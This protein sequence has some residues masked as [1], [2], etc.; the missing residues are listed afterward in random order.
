M[1]N[2]LSFL[3]KFSPGIY[4]IAL[5]FAL[6]GDNLDPEYQTGIENKLS[7]LEKFPHETYFK[8]PQDFFSSWIERRFLDDQ[9]SRFCYG[10]E[11]Q[12]LTIDTTS[13]S[14]GLFSQINGLVLASDLAYTSDFGHDFIFVLNDVTNKRVLTYH[15]EEGK[16]FAEDP[17]SEKLLI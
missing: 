15:D 12:Q 10:F 17:R 11:L 9:L 16:H 13:Y 8:T 14:G 2:P 3:H 1:T 7:R 6:E 4:R 5:F